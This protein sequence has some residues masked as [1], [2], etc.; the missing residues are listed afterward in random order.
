MT[1][2]KISRVIH[3][4]KE[5]KEKNMEQSNVTEEKKK[6]IGNEYLL[7]LILYK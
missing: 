3:R 7:Y 2:K 4:L 6:N 1:E 5:E